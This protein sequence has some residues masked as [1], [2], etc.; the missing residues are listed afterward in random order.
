MLSA[1]DAALVLGKVP[2]YLSRSADAFSP[3]LLRNF[4]S[5]SSGRSLDDLGRRKEFVAA[6][7]LFSLSLNAFTRRCWCDSG[8]RSRRIHGSL[9]SGKGPAAY[10][11][12][13]VGSALKK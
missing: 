2:S 11:A 8:A 4:F 13:E 9:S 10:P 7:H 6:L 12:V 5:L 3:T 1:A